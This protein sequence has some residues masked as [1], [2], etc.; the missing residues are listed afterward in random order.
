MEFGSF[1]QGTDAQESE[2]SMRQASL[3]SV[4][5]KDRYFGT[6][7]QHRMCRRLGLSVSL[8]LSSASAY[9]A[10]IID[11]LL[12]CGIMVMGVS[13]PRWRI[14]PAGYLLGPAFPS[15]DVCSIRG[16]YVSLNVSDFSSRRVGLR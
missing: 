9:Q 3:I 11:Q 8:C 15:F 2:R 4:N 5:E 12:F 6:I 10:L 1:T 14:F 7:L 16:K 13:F